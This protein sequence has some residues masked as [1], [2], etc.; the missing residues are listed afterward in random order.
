MA[1][2]VIKRRTPT[3]RTR[4]S[5]KSRST[6]RKTKTRISYRQ[7][8]Y[9]RDAKGRFASTG[10]SSKSTK[11][12]S[13]PKRT[14]KRKTAVAVG[15]GTAL[16]VGAKT[17]KKRRSAK[18]AANH[19]RKVRVEKK[20]QDL[21][22]AKRRRQFDSTKNDKK[23]AGSGKKAETPETEETDTTTSVV[24]R[25]GGSTGTAQAMNAAYDKPEAPYAVQTVPVRW[26]NRPRRN[27]RCPAGPRPPQYTRPG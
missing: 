18:A 16:V 26:L 13:R 24:C 17:T 5:Y 2:R 1:R 8:T 10:S 23:R 6:R 14:R 22:N 25:A 7:T 27:G 9:K 3:S 20:A 21:I 19:A 12:T 4:V 15:A 11:S